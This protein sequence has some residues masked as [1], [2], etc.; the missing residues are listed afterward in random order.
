VALEGA[1][2]VKLWGGQGEVLSDPPAY[3]HD[4][5]SVHREKGRKSHDPQAQDKVVAMGQAGWPSQ[6]EMSRGKMLVT[7]NIL[8]RVVTSD[9]TVA[10]KLAISGFGIAIL[11]AWMAK[12][13]DVQKGLVQILPQWIPEPITLCALFASPSRLTPKVQV[14]L[15]FLDE[16]LGTDRDPA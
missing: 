13:P 5:S 15:D 11:P 8:F 1:L 10:L 12:Q 16:Y 2:E 4:L 7:P 3:P 14:L 9:P 6:E